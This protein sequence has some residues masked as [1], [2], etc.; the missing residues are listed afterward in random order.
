M[1]AFW[2]IALVVAC[3]SD[4]EGDPKQFVDQGGALAI[5]NCDYTLTTRIGAERPVPSG[6]TIGP[7]AT[8]RA[9]HL[10]IIGDPKTSIVAQWRTFDEVT[11]AGSIRYGVGANLPEAQLTKTVKGIQFAYEGTGTDIFRMHQAHLCDLEPGTT[12]SYQVGHGDTWS[13]VYTFHTAPDVVAH[14]DAVAYVT[15]LYSRSS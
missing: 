13:H 2:A 7:D 15:I 4:N 9:V 12:Y 6:K 10:G 11:T 3:D 14:P 1:R 5:D 8:P